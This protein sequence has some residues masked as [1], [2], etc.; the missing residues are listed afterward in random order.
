MD[1]PKIW[2]IST[3]FNSKE[4]LDLLT[5]HYSMKHIFPMLGTLVG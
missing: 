5:G 3:I 1:N 2:G 4:H